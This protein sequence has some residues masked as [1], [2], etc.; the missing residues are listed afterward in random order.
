MFFLEEEPSCP[1]TNRKPNV[2]DLSVLGLF[3]KKMVDFFKKNHIRF[4]RLHTV[5]TKS[6]C[7]RPMNSFKSQK[8]QTDPLSRPDTKP[9]GTR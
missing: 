8:L 5:H 9:Q 6:Q 3:K 2:L 1:Q 7:P 4:L